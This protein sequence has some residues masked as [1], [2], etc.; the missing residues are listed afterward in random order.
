[1]TIRARGCILQ[2]TCLIN[3]GVLQIYS[4]FYN[5]HLRGAARRLSEGAKVRGALAPCLQHFMPDGTPR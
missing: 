1:M 4:Q 3:T 2:Q 5:L